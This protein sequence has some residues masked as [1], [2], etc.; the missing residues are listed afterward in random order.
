[1]AIMAKKLYLSCKWGKSGIAMLL[2]GCCT[3][4]IV[5]LAKP[6]SYTKVGDQQQYVLTLPP[7]IVMTCHT[8]FAV[9]GQAKKQT[10]LLL[11]PLSKQ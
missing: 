11:H 1:M 4:P 6:S 10:L 5:Q 3:K 9:T 7:P 8:L 2:V